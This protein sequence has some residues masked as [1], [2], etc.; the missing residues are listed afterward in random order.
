MER[1]WLVNIN[2]N[3]EILVMKNTQYF[4]PISTNEFCSYFIGQSDDFFVL[5]INFKSSVFKEIKQ[6]RRYSAQA[7]IGN[8]GGYIGLLLGY[9]IK[10]FPRML[11][12]LFMK[13]KK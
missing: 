3:N 7:L 11:Q 8:A 13:T 2:S 1:K 12:F 9:T 5:N 4:S 10:E 6:V